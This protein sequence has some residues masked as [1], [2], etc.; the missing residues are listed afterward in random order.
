[1][2]FTILDRASKQA[3]SIQICEE[4]S[5][6]LQEKNQKY[7]CMIELK[8][9]YVLNNLAD[10]EALES[11]RADVPNIDKIHQSLEIYACAEIVRVFE[12]ETNVGYVFNEMEGSKYQVFGLKEFEK[13]LL[14][15]PNQDRSFE[16]ASIIMQSEIRKLSRNLLSFLQVVAN[17]LL[18]QN[19]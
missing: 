15:S 9:Q 8:L 16:Y 6:L 14:A 7:K 2:I 18:W 11:Y 10:K 1:M 5:R 3:I 13:N 12:K 17:V 19:S 4:Y